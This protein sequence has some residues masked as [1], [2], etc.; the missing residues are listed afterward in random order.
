M[1]SEN[2]EIVRAGIQEWN[3]GD[4]EALLARATEDFEWHP[5][6]VQ[7]V[8]GKAFRGHAEFREFLE[9]WNR[10]WESW[11]LEIQELRD[12]GDRVLA[13]TRVR[14]KGRGS[15]VEFNQPIAQIFD[16][17]GGLIC[18]GETFLDQG[19]AIAAA[20]RREEAA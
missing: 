1:S 15:G 16:L 20:E 3:R 5:T 11:D 14:A 8:E 6:L 17:R 7:N 9:E 19:E 13:L 4:V 2:V 12:F 10:T 18:R